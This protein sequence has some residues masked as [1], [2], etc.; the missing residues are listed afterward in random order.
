MIIDSQEV[1]KIAHRGPLYN[2]LFPSM[3]TS[4]IISTI[5]K[6]ANWYWY[7]PQPLF[8]FHQFCLHSCGFW[9]PLIFE[10]YFPLG[11]IVS[12]PFLFSFSSLK[13]SSYCLLGCVVSDKMSTVIPF[14]L[15]LPLR[16]FL[17]LVFSNFIMM[18]FLSFVWGECLFCLKLLSFL[19]LWVLVFIKFGKFWLLFLQIFFLYSNTL[20]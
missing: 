6:P 19:N 12:W 15:S 17:S 16:H 14:F 3:V 8:R 20:S 7:N 2:S 13:M 4:N 11:I 1:S 5:S 10:R 9:G 18:R